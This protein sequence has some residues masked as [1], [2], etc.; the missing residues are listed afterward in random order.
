MSKVHIA[1]VRV[2]GTALNGDAVPVAGSELVGTP[3]TITSSGSSQSST[4]TAST[5]VVDQYN[6]DRYFW[7]IAVGGTDDVYAS[8]GSS[9][10]ASESTGYLLPAGGVYEFRV[11]T[12]GNKVAVINA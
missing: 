4:I 11:T 3:E 7:R 10:T 9:P 5:S 6:L 2:T 8:F 12:V 1:I